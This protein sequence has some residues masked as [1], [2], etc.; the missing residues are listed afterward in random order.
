M[1]QLLRRCMVPLILLFVTQA[2]AQERIITGTVTADGKAVPGV[3]V[4]VKGT[5]TGSNTNVDGIYK[6][7]VSASKGA[8]IFSSVGYASQQAAFGNQSII[9]VVLAADNKP[10]EEAVVIGYGTQKRKDLTG[11]VSSVKAKDLVIASGPEIGNML[12]GK[13]AGLTIRQNSAQPGGGLDILV[14]GAGSVNASNAPL[15]VV[16]GFPISDLQQPET[17]GRY[18]AGTQSILSSFNPND[19]ESIEVL[20]DASTTSIYGSRAANGVILITTKKGKDGAPVVQYANNFSVQKYVNRFDVLPLNEWMQLRNEAGQEQW[21]FDNGVFPYGT[22]TLEEAQASPI[23]GLYHKLYTQN[24]INNVGR[25]TDWISLVTRDGSTRQHNLSIS[26]GTKLTKY[27]ISGNYYD[28]NGVVKNAGFKRY[29]IRANVDQELNKYLKFGLNLTASRINNTNSSL[30]GD[31]YENSGVIRGAIQQGPHIQAID[32][33]GNY[34]L[35]PQLALQPNPLSLLTITDKGITER[36]LINTYLDITPIKDLLIRFKAGMDRGN[37]KRES[38][39]PSTTVNGATENGRAFIGN[40]DNNS[41]LLEVTANYNKTIARNHKID[42]LAGVSKQKFINTSSTSSSSGFITDA[43][44]WNNLGAGS[45]PIASSSFGAENLIASYF[46]RI[47]YNY[48]GRYMLTATV[49]TDGAS[50]F[51]VNNKWGTFPSAA[52]AWNVAEEPFFRPLSGLFNQ[53]KL[54]FSYGQT[55]NASINSNAFAAYNAYPAWLSATDTR[56]IGVSLSRLENPSLKWETTTGANFGLD[57]SMLQGRI[58]G[59]VEIFN[60]VISDLLDTKTLNSYNEVNTIIANVG[61]TQSKGFEITINTHNVQ[62]SNFQWRTIFA[63]SHYKDNWKERAPDW[64]PRVYESANDPIRPNYSRISDGILQV[65]E[66]APASQPE[67]K[68]GMIKIKD[69]DGFQRDAAGHPM[70]DANGRFL[71][72][73]KSDGIIDDADTKLLGTTDPSYMIGVTNI[74]TYKRFSLNFDFNGLLGR[75]MEDPNFVA[76]GVSAYGVY[77]NGYNALR[78][79]KNRW[80]PTN[81]STTQPSSFWGFSPYGVGDFYLQ[82]AWFIRLQ[83]VSLGYN[84]PNKWL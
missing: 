27:L 76:Y 23:N 79:V 7:K 61:K 74:L 80:T 5:A 84:L 49:R 18:Q 47:N 59:S 70:V 71:R 65:G 34:P 30:G 9:D 64:K 68:P 31:Q 6:I 82:K 57:F 11:A 58:D 54:R 4:L 48:K 13:V 3:S 53:F 28:Q 35:N 51:A 37:A 62:T 66:K 44:L 21:N 50:V 60:N 32:E 72:T 26:G 83:N 16:D 39:I 33:N 19:I 75:R 52:V 1:N 42:I 14:R 17:G 15:I 20:K 43:F 78:S 24:A 29:S 45:N 63:F 2:S 25:G 67:L 8:L 22:K 10:L 12:K 77:S 46:G 55:G 56:L 36:T 73:G 41:Y 38:Y 40:T 69:F 81:P